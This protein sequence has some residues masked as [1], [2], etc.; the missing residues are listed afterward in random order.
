MKR[1]L[2]S[3]RRYLA[4][5][6][7]YCPHC[8]M[9]VQRRTYDEHRRNFYDEVAKQWNNTKDDTHHDGSESD[10]TTQSSEPNS[11]IEISSPDEYISSPD[12]SDMY[13]GLDGL[14]DMDRDENIPT[15]AQESSDEE[16][17]DESDEDNEE[18]RHNDNNPQAKS[19]VR[20]LVALLLAFQAAYAIP[21]MA[22][23]WL[24]AFL[25][26]VFT[27]LYS[28]CPS[29][30]ICAVV[31]LLPCSLYLAW[32]LLHLHDDDFIRYVVCPKC[33]S[34][35]EY[36]ECIVRIGSELQS[37]RCSYIAFPN[38]PFA[39]YRNPCNVVL[40]KKVTLKH[41]KTKL[42]PKKE[43][44]YRSII[45]SLNVLLQRPDVLEKLDAWKQR[46]V[47]DG[48]LTDI[49]DGKIWKEF[50]AIN[51]EPF[52]SG[53]TTYGLMLNVDWFKPFK[54]TQYKVGAIYLVV[55]NFPRSERFLRENLI[56]VGIIPG[57]SEP[58]HVMN[59]Y[60]TPMI[61]ELQDLWKGVEMKL[62]TGNK[63]VR[64]A[65]LCTGCDIP[66]SKKLCGFRGF[67][68]SR[69]CNRCFK[70]FDGSGFCKS[71]ADFDRNLWPKR[72][73]FDHRQ[74]AEE[75]KKA[76][77]LGEKERL[78]IEYGLRY[79]SL[80][81][82]P[83]Y[84]AIRMS[85]IIDPLHNL[86]L[87]TTK[88]IF[89]DVWLG[90]G[91]IPHKILESVQSRMANIVCPEDTGRIP[92]NIASNFGGFT[93]N[94][95][96][97]WTEL[98]SLIVLRDKL[99][100]AHLECWKHFV[101]ASRLLSRVSLSTTDLLLADALLLQFCRR[102]VSLYGEEVATPNM[103]LHA[104]I[105]ECIEDYGP[106]PGF[107][108]F[109]FE[110]YNGILGRQP[111][112]NHS[113]EIQIM[114]RFTRESNLFRLQPSTEFQ[115]QFS[116]MYPLS[117][118]SDVQ[119]KDAQTISTTHWAQMTS[120]DL[121]LV[122]WTIDFT[123]FKLPT[124]SH[125]YILSSDEQRY[126]KQMY[127]HLYPQLSESD[128]SIPSSIRKYSSVTGPLFRYDSNGKGSNVL[129]SWADQAQINTN[130]QDQSPG[131]V[132][133]YFTHSI[134]LDSI[135]TQHLIAYVMWYEPHPNRNELGKPLEA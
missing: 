8:S 130:N 21:Y 55:L 107:W 97:N 123:Y 7:V 13:A 44:P 119:N 54:R 86:Y 42:V 6:R 33:E 83:Y 73:N 120:S 106:T 45:K 56:L 88:H 127:T 61:K 47:P 62:P 46:S 114:R 53:E 79:S 85:S 93:G 78:E 100:G 22:T 50:M 16:H 41:G 38:H 105:R 4:S 40:L 98:F 27:V 94:Q 110:R 20:W 37:K 36:H 18:D 96:K 30:F 32:K 91:I 25:H 10:V 34:L 117:G 132:Q 95:W 69:G 71:Y 99:T 89:E 90:K 24:F 74:K 134:L 3:S 1:S 2:P 81:Q 113:P 122:K 35:Y 9:Q 51:D 116:S 111:N 23:H 75:V 59:T 101:L 104:H 12:I 126:L 131:K 72:T 112:N 77:T 109:A 17:W 15:H 135:L 76:T 31:S 63:M 82:L 28:V 5:K 49:Y 65:L 68:S 66:A 60:L 92:S 11:D 64:A 108:L 29:P 67:G 129:A 125:R 14:T 43:Y 39:R 87:G 52:L 80:L 57:P 124:N 70:L 102:C 133:Y 103:H 128:L 58:N 26:T 84:D 115:E 48:L 121:T 118:V 19:F